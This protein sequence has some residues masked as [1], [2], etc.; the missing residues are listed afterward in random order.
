MKRIKLRKKVNLSPRF[1]NQT[2]ESHLY[3]KLEL[4]LT[5]NC[6]QQ[7][8]YVISVDRKITIMDN[9][10]IGDGHT[11]CDVEFCIE[12]LKP[13]EG[14]VLEGI[15][16]MVF[17]GGIFVEIQGKMKVLVP[18]NKISKH[19]YDKLTGVFVHKKSVISQGDTV[20]VKLELI[21]YDH[22]GFNCIGILTT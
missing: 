9:E 3:T 4:L 14:Q 10:I 6:T 20:S 2:I 17:E 16:C 21:K 12:T 11:L 13:A 8:G 7:D 19:K 5:G 18:A 15:V 22:R 1:L